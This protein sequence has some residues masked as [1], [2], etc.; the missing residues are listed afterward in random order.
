MVDTEYMYMLVQRKT[1]HVR[2][3]KPRHTCKGRRTL[4]MYIHVHVQ[5]YT[6][7]SIIIKPTP[8][9]SGFIS[10]TVSILPL[11]DTNNNGI[12]IIQ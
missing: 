8:L 1:V 10:S 6:H 12:T 4:D 3:D 9:C 2:T 11:P 5:M 7:S